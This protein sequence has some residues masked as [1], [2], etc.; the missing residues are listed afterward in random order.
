MSGRYV[1]TSNC[2]TSGTMNLTL[3]LRNYLQGRDNVTFRDEDG[4]SYETQVNWAR[5]RIEGL[6][7]YY[8]KRRLSANE[9]IALH[10]EGEEIGLEALTPTAKPAKPRR[11]PPQPE[12]AHPEPAKVEKV[13]KPQKRV[14]VTPYPREVLFPQ[15]P[16]S[17]EAPAFAADL[18]VLG[19]SRESAG[20][21]WTFRAALGRRAFTL[22]L[23]RFGEMEAKELLAF[24]QSGRVQ[25]AAIVA[26]ESSRSEAL[27]E[28]A[29]VRPSGLGQ[30]GLAYV[31]PEALGR[32]VKLQG[33]FPIGALDIEKL[34]R[35]GRLDLE[36]IASLESEISGVLGERGAF[37]AVLTL[38][39]EL[40]SQQIFLL[41]DLMPT[42]R[43]M[44][45]EADHLQG[46]LETLSSPPFLLLKRLS[47]GEFLMRQTV[48][49]ALSDWTEYAR[50]ME[51]RLEGMRL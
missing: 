4:D 30:V 8:D 50:V 43:E 22:A 44:N 48:S 17:S 23:A 46:V 16:Q 3:T 24:R 6:G 5:G 2:L 7:A 47:P 31:S 18:E 39:C 35:E 9:I 21:P 26:G 29:S 38:L 41:A 40:S 42:A 11:G 33:A 20:L 19:L 34:L 36:S 27:S 1:L 25:Y 14:K 32:L 45:L 12:P 49:R 37:S 51:R 10:F 28:I 15:I 13:E